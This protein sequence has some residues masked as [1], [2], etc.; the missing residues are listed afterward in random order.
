MPEKRMVLMDRTHVDTKNP[1]FSF[2][3]GAIIGGGDISRYRTRFWTSRNKTAETFLKKCRI[4]RMPTKEQTRLMRKKRYR[5]ICINSQLISKTLKDEIKKGD[6]INKHFMK[7]FLL[8]RS[9]K[10]YKR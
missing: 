2:L 7:G 1:A 8:T 3:L 10:I 5:I 9:F 6:Y 4:L